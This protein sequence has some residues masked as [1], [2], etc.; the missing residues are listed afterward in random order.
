MAEEVGEYGML[1]IPAAVSKS[2]DAPT[3]AHYRSDTL[4]TNMILKSQTGMQGVYQ[5]AAEMT[6]LGFIVSVTSR[7]AFG[8]DLLVT[9]QRCQT[10]WSVQVKTNHQKMSFWLLNKHAKEIKSPT[11]VYVFVTL[12]KNQR[13]DYHVVSSEIVST[14]VC[15]DQT[16][17]GTWY[18]FG[19]ADA[20]Q[21][22]EGW[23]VF[24]NP[25]PSPEA[26]LDPSDQVETETIVE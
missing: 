8:A 1:H 25:G 5:V 11:H 10:S 12:K 21:D 23:E 9:D 16:K 3:L 14:H 20:K 13:P 18:S 7:S 19:L 24:G 17:G 15:E 26:L 22:S 6:H 4:R 2:S